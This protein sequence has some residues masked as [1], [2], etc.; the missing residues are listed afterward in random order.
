M[1]AVYAGSFDP[2]TVG[3]MKIL[4]QAAEIFDKVYVCIANNSDKKRCFD[5]KIMKQAIERT[6][7]M[8]GLTNCEVVIWEGMIVDF[9]TKYNADYLVRGLRDTTDYLYEE[10]IAKINH[11]LNPVLR[12]IYFRATSADAISSSMVREF[13][14]YGKP[15]AKYLPVDVYKTILPEIEKGSNG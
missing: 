7:Y 5:V 12:T 9:C 6:L 15:I 13:I 8:N 14:K 2:F 4:R 1:K 11:E 3:H 10:N